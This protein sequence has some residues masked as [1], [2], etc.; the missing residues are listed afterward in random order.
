MPRLSYTWRRYI[1]YLHRYVYLR[2]PKL[3]PLV[4]TGRVSR[5]SHTWRWYIV[6]LHHS[7]LKFKKKKSKKFRKMLV[8]YISLIYYRWPKFFEVFLIFFLF[9]K[10]Q[11]TVLTHVC[12]LTWQ[13]PEIPTSAPNITFSAGYVTIICIVGTEWVGMFRFRL[14]TYSDFG[15]DRYKWRVV[16]GSE[17]E[18][19]GSLSMVT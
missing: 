15:H 6:Y 1:I 13:T 16:C 12:L 19:P 7:H 18:R 9:L 8:I 2:G 3:L 17:L 14:R 11:V 4:I 10:L 5:L